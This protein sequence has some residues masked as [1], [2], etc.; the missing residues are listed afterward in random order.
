MEEPKEEVRKKRI[1]EVL[2]TGVVEFTDE[3]LDDMARRWE[4]RQKE[5]KE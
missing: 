3:D 5:K 2:A 1:E 4:T